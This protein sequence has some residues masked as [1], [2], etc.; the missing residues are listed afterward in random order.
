MRAETAFKARHPEIDFDALHEL[1]RTEYARLDRDGHIY[2]DY[3]GG[4]LYAESQL[5]VHM[6]LLSNGVYGNPHSGNPTSLAMTRLDDQA[7][8][9]VLD[10]FNADPDEYCV[11]FAPNAS[12]ALR[13]VG[14]SYP[15]EERGCY[16]LTVDNHNSVN[17]IREYA[18]AAGAQVIYTPLSP[19][20]MR[21]DHEML[22]DNLDRAI[23]DGNN[24]FA[25]PAQSNFTGVRHSLEWIEIARRKGRNVL[26]DCAAFVP[27]N[28]LDLSVVK[29]DFV[30]LSF[31][32]NV[33]YPTGVG[34]LIARRSALCKL[35]RRWFAGGTITVVSA[36]ADRHVLEEGVAAFEGGTID[37]LGLPA[38]EIGLECIQYVGME[39]IHRRVLSMTQFL[40][41]ELMASDD[42]S[43]GSIWECPNF[44]R[45]RSSCCCA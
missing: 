40:L 32:K 45:L 6:Q 38:I 39:Q 28:R 33:G 13:L 29:P 17:G 43:I 4:G 44:F 42:P 18:K 11:I 1:R 30:P 22:L 16:L 34:A 35:R 20:D 41:D 14:E 25:Y 36:Q 24:L 12:G 2:L 5:Q 19:L 10:Y 23:P 27:S 3:T 8:S 9:F 31:Y 7:R 37:Y 21:L 26:V 15:F